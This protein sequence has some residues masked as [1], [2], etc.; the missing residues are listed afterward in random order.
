MA[1]VGGHAN[2]YNNQ[3]TNKTRN[4]QIYQNAF[5]QGGAGGNPANTN[6]LAAGGSQLADGA[7]G[8]NYRTTDLKNPMQRGQS[9]T[10]GGGGM[11]TVGALVGQSNGFHGQTMG[12][13]GLDQRSMSK[14]SHNRQ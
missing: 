12:S 4:P 10:V 6:F 8:F 14:D 1:G 13:Q 3:S 5:G 9:H 7:Q 11:T 2:K